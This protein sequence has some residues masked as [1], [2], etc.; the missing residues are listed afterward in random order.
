[1][2]SAGETS[3]PVSTPPDVPPGTMRAPIRL[4]PSSNDSN[5]VSTALKVIEAERLALEHLEH[6]YRT[7]KG[8]QESLER[9]VTHI[10]RSICAGGKCIIAGVGKSGKIGQ[11]IVATMNSLGVPSVFLHPTEAIHGDLGVIGPVYCFHF[12]YVTDEPKREGKGA[13]DRVIL[14]YI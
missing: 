7:D 11:K 4:S 1:M 12:P 14:D 5:V 6:V 9:A 8:A 2:P 10:V 13:R 3:V